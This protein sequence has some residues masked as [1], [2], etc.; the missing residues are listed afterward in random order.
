MVLFVYAGGWMWRRMLAEVV[1]NLTVWRLFLQ[2]QDSRIVI[3]KYCGIA[4][5]AT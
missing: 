4:L 3:V 5:N 2:V 1:L